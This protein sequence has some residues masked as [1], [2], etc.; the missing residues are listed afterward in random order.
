M[1][2]NYQY[3]SVNSTETKRSVDN[4]ENETI[5]KGIAVYG[6]P[7]G[8]LCLSKPTDEEH[9]TVSIK[10]RIDGEFR[11][12]FCRVEEECKAPKMKE[13]LKKENKVYVDYKNRIVTLTLDSCD[14]PYIPLRKLLIQL[15]H[16][17][18]DNILFPCTLS[19]SIGWIVF[20]N[21]MAYILVQNTHQL[22]WWCPNLRD[23]KLNPQGDNP[24]RIK[25]EK[26]DNRENVDSK[27]V[28]VTT[29]K[30]EMDDKTMEKW[31]LLEAIKI[32]AKNKYECKPEE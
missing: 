10:C 13:T 20:N 4:E 32:C 11:C 3:L 5:K 22:T 29:P 18:V 17:K 27:K 2:Q 6:Y 24:Y 31:N 8:S 1:T 25:E 7:G 14:E 16:L 21:L 23:F 12:P 9:F 19:S 30:E 28:K 26:D 15:H